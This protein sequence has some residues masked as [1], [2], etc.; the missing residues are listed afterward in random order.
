MTEGT[1]KGL[2]IVVAIVIFGIFVGLSYLI[3][4]DTLNPAMVELFESAFGRN[5]DAEPSVPETDEKL[6]TFTES[7]N[8]MTI[9]DYI[10]TE[11]E[12]SIPS[13]ATS[14]IDGTLK[15]VTIIGDQALANKNLETIKI[16]DSVVILGTYSFAGN[17]LTKI[18]IPNSVETIG[19]SAFQSNVN[20]ETI[21]IG[22]SVKTI[23]QTTFA[24]SNHIKS[25][26]IGN[27]VETI[28][29]R[30]FSTGN[31]NGEISLETIDELIIPASV[32]KIGRMAFFNQQINKL[33]ADNG[34]ETIGVQAFNY[35]G[36][37]EVTLPDSMKT[38]ESMAFSYGN[39]IETLDL[40]NCIETIE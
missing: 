4:E 40:G 38:V 15:P 20:L 29:E 22:N 16:P 23:E 7:N 12:I 14:K 36:L 11:T 32:K 3:F 37:E 9:T 34:L 30:A 31:T 19:S 33:T 6:F 2:F 13:K 10:G 1:N 27:S 17:M 5:K 8:E 18:E 26:T 21:V 39:A 24:Y 28:G 35:T 25:I